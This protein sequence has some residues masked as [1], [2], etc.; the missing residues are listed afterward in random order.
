MKF[1]QWIKYNKRNIFFE[2]YCAKWGGETSPTPFLKRDQNWACLIAFTFGVAGS[3]FID[4]LG[5]PACDVIT[6]EIYRSFMIR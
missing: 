3:M 6:F 4:I 2:K 5:V 1:R